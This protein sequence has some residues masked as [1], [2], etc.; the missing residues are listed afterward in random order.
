MLG[1]LT[2][3]KAQYTTNTTMTATTTITSTTTPIID[4]NNN[5]LLCYNLGKMYFSELRDLLNIQ[6][7]YIIFIGYL[8]KTKILLI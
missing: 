1:E 4:N 5:R 8:I 2:L 7:I 6:Y 3:V